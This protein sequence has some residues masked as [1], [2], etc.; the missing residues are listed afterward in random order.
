MPKKND[1]EP[2]TTVSTTWRCL[3]NV[4]VVLV[5]TIV[6]HMGQFARRTV[7]QWVIPFLCIFA[8]QLVL[9]G[10]VRIAELVEKH[11]SSVVVHCTDGW[12]RTAQLAALAMLMLDSYYR[13]IR[14]FQVKDRVTLAIVIPNM[15]RSMCNL[16]QVNCTM[17]HICGHLNRNWF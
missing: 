6:P 11:K 13:T 17:C 9:G 12:D 2:Q 1:Q 15:S 5:C 8:L 16:V 3:V 14:G 7:V 10:A 4:W